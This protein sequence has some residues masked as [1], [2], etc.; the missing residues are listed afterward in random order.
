MTLSKGANQRVI[1]TRTKDKSIH[2]IKMGEEAGKTENK[3][4]KKPVLVNR[5]GN[6]RRWGRMDPEG[7]IARVREV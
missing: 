6:W 5:E 2:R 4:T 1:K 3:Q 7:P